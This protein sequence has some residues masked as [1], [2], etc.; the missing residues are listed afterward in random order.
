[1]LK[2]SSIIYFFHSVVEEFQT[3]AIKK[4]ILAF[5]WGNGVFLEATIPPGPL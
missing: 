2:F 4:P 1:M 3:G 5:E